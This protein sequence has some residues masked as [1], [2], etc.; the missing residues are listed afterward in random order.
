MKLSP[1]V[2]FNAINY[3]MDGSEENKPYALN[4]D[5]QN[6]LSAEVGMGLNVSKAYTIDQTQ[7]M[8]V[9]FG[10]MA[11]HEFMD[12]YELK[13]S[14]KGM[15]GSWRIRDERRKDN[16]ITVNGGFEYKVAPFAIYGNV[17]SYIDS[18]YNTKAD[19]GFKFDF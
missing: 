16:H 7:N 10:L 13:L 2:E 3:L 1:T 6:V 11:Y 5:K 17:F 8:K 12:P 15:D 18:E 9:N 14:M 19:F 4:I